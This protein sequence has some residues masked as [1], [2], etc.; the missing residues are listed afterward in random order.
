MMLLM[1]CFLFKIFGFCIKKICVKNLIDIFHKNKFLSIF[2]NSTT[3]KNSILI[4]KI[5][6]KKIMVVYFCFI[7]IYQLN[8]NMTPTRL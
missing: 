2:L 1:F 3:P 7:V 4:S 5:F 6:K 8:I